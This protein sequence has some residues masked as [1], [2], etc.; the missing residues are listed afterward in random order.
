MQGPSQSPTALPNL[1]VLEVA[2]L[3]PGPYCGKLLASLGAEVIKAEPPGVGGPS[4]RRSP[5]VRGIGH[6]AAKMGKRI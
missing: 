3:I 2:S 5:P 6:Q 4:R 1:R